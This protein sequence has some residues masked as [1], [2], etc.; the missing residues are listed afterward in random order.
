MCS[1]STSVMILPSELHLLILSYI[2]YP[3][4]LANR[5]LSCHF[6]NLIL[7]MMNSFS[8][9]SDLELSR[10]VG[11]SFFM[12][13]E[14]LHLER[15]MTEHSGSNSNGK[16]RQIL[17]AHMIIEVVDRLLRRSQ[18][19][20]TATCT[21][22]HHQPRLTDLHI[23]YFNLN[24]AGKMTRDSYET[25]F[26]SSL[27]TICGEQISQQVQRLSI[28][29][30]DAN[31]QLIGKYLPLYCDS[32]VELN[33]WGNEKLTNA[34][35]MKL[36]NSSLKRR[37]K[38]LEMGAFNIALTD[39]S[40][41]A[42]ADCMP[43]LE[44]LNLRRCAALTDK[45]VTYLA[46]KLTNLKYLDFGFNQNVTNASVK[47]MI[48]N[49][50]QLEHLKLRRCCITEE[51]LQNL[52]NLK[53]L[54]ELN[55]CETQVSS[56]KPLLG[57]AHSLRRLVV[58]RCEKLTDLSPLAQ[59]RELRHLSLAHFSRVEDTVLSAWCT[60]LEHL[61]YLEICCGRVTDSSFVKLT[62]L[63]H[64]IHLH[65]NYACKMTDESF[66]QICDSL[67]RLES[68]TCTKCEQITVNAA[69]HL[70]NLRHLK[71]LDLTSGNLRKRLFDDQLKFFLRIP[72]L[73]L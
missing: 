2:P 33:L 49:L 24:F 69:V 66:I 25:M 43:Q 68:F 3:A 28:L 29:T 15:L 73:K 59:L 58:D 23:K 41:Y 16:Q 48:E 9:S 10:L 26:L 31:D 46:Y 34:T 57:V 19:Q 67:H 18:Q 61:E 40:L 7:P 72:Q 64:L 11:S 4:N 1:D 55:I 65:L 39:C 14:K 50:T 32:L 51:G 44:H 12:F 13:I 47:A 60:N 37:L 6:N 27:F 36:V 45:S 62:N 54:K 63:R 17:T 21:L 53:H 22:S 30:L 70:S 20:N 8:A 52:H 35:V 56:L 38:H 42:I 5:L 71:D